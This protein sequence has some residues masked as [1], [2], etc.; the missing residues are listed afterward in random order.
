MRFNGCPHT[1]SAFSTAIGHRAV[2]SI[3]PA[4]ALRVLHSRRS[5]AAS[6]PVSRPWCRL[7]LK[8]TVERY[9]HTSG[10]QNSDHMAGCKPAVRFESSAN[11]MGGWGP[12]FGMSIR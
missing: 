6:C 11:A 3:P 8:R 2:L 5:R 4:M 1:A 10:F 12:V 7:D 9:A